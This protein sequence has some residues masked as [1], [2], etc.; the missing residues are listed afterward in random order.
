MKLEQ[1]GKKETKKETR[2]W[3]VSHTTKSNLHIKYNFIQNLMT[4]FTE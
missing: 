2:Q 4:F 1:S 3:E